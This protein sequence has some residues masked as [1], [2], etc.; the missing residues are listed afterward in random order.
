MKKWWQDTEHTERYPCIESRDQFDER[1]LCLP[2][3]SFTSVNLG[4][5]Q[6]PP[7]TLHVCMCMGG[8]FNFSSSRLHGFSP[9][10]LRGFSSNIIKNSYK[11]YTTKLIIFLCII[12][13]VISFTFVN[14]F[15]SKDRVKCI[16]FYNC[17]CNFP[18]K[19]L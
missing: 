6:I 10:T 14:Y 5:V 7:Q 9:S 11:N 15:I 16:V 18:N 8:F 19:L 1:F 12:L 2:F 13:F 3:N 4:V 17:K